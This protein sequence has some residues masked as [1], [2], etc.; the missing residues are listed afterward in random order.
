MSKAHPLQLLLGCV[1]TLAASLSTAAETVLYDASANGGNALV[2]SPHLVGVTAHQWPEKY[3]WEG[4]GSS[5]SPSFGYDVARSHDYWWWAT[6]ETSP[7]TYDWKRYD[8]WVN[9][10]SSKACILVIYGTPEFHASNGKHKPVGYNFVAGNS[11][12]TDASLSAFAKAL[13]ERY[14]GKCAKGVYIEA[15]NEISDEN[16]FST[17]DPNVWARVSKTVYD[18]VK[19]V[20]PSIRVIGPSNVNGPDRFRSMIQ[21]MKSMNHKPDA[22]AYHFYYTNPS[23]YATQI[24]Q[25]RSVMDSEG[26][27]DVNLFDTEHGFTPD[28]LGSNRETTL[29]QMLAVAA[30]NRLYTVVQF[31]KDNPYDKSYVLLDDDAGTRNAMTWATQNLSGKSISK[32]TITTSGDVQVTYASS[33][34]TSSTT[35][36]SSPSTTTSSSPSTTTSSSPSTTTSSSP[37]TSTSSSSTKT[38]TQNRPWWRSLFR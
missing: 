31:S 35:T 37:T 18:A 22:L 1:V 25:M 14:S 32:L 33:Q 23:S 11:I 24:R 2:V 9:A 38:T 10:N 17:L 5:P 20:A 16:Y 26:W 6:T 34:S 8:A 4:T 27:S 13:A 7:G 30:A 21:A 12:P 3:P 28:D 15:W 36:S 29:K 19:S